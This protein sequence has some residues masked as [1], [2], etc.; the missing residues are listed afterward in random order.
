MTQENVVNSIMRDMRFEGIVT[1]DNSDQ[2][3]KFLEQV[4]VGGWEYY[5]KYETHRGESV[6]PITE[7]GRRDEKLGD[8]PSIAEAERITKIPRKTI[9][10]NMQVKGRRM[11]NGHYFRYTEQGDDTV[12][13]G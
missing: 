6:R 3:Q 10:S 8:F 7:Y 9:Q 13:V 12:D 5:R 4:W 2:V 11:R 1:D